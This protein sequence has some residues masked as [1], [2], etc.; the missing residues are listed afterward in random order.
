MLQGLALSPERSTLNF[1]VSQV[2]VFAEVKFPGL[3]VL[4]EEI[5]GAFAEDFALMQQVGAVNDAEGLADVVVRDDDTNASGLELED[6]FLHLGDRDRID[7]REG[8][9]HEEKFGARD[10]G[11]GDFEPAAFA[12]G[13]R[14]GFLFG[15]VREG[16]LGEVFLDAGGARTA[17]DAGD[18][19][20]GADVLFDREFPED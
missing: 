9:V 7:G 3:L 20:D 1:R 18:F 11:A 14:V 4:D 17:G 6:D 19:D 13:E 8:L 10:Q 16:Q 15:D 12:P 2:E 5:A